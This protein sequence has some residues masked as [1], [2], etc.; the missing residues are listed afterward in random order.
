M[1]SPRHRFPIKA[2]SLIIIGTMSS[3]VMF[4]GCSSGKKAE[5]AIREIM[6]EQYVVL[7]D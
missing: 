3:V 6:L 1:F 5:D 4:A 7:Y 2:F